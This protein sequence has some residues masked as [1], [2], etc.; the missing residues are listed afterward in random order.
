MDTWVIVLIIVVVL[1]LLAL[2]FLMPR[3]RRNAQARAREHELQQRRENA[4]R[5]ERAQAEERRS[6]AEQAEL[7][8]R[9]AATEAQR[10]RAEADLRDQRAELHER[11]MADH[12]LIDESERDRFAG[13][14]AMGGEHAP[15]TGA[16]PDVVRSDETDPV[17][18]QHVRG[19]AEPVDG[20]SGDYE[21]GRIDERREQATDP[22]DPSRPRPA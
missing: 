22:D 20:Y 4:V 11:G 21:Q 7:K 19:G 1:I 16:Q 8:A 3:A 5:E 2:L 13:T 14:S 17:R 15:A 9:M 18:G 10:E 6:Q 12:E